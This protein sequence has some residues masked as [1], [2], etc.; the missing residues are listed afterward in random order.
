[1]TIVPFWD[2][3][4][5]SKQYL[6]T[7]FRSGR[8]AIGRSVKRE[9]YKSMLQNYIPIQ[10]ESYEFLDEHLRPI[11]PSP[12]T[13]PSS[14]LLW[15]GVGGE[16]LGTYVRVI[17][18]NGGIYLAK[19]VPL[20]DALPRGWPLTKPQLYA[21]RAA[22]FF[23]LSAIGLNSVKPSYT[24]HSEAFRKTGSRW[25]YSH[26]RQFGDI[27]CHKA[28]YWAWKGA[29]PAGCQI[30]HKDGNPLNNHIDNLEDVTP[31]ENRR[32]AKRLRRLRKLGSEG[33]YDVMFKYGYDKLFS[34][35][36]D[37]FNQLLEDYSSRPKDLR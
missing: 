15:R 23:S 24:L 27:T 25:R 10:V 16:V 31:A 14:P 30:D 22:N 32:R 4:Q 35:S 33:W 6:C 36:E 34:L 9:T 8:A 17:S 19:R 3:C 21:T 26:M 5:F 1:M 13:P 7:V 11:T 29:I 20:E 12:S 37:D 2:S 28:V 18:S